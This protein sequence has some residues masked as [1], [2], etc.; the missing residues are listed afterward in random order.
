MKPLFAE[1][2]DDH[3]KRLESFYKLTAAILLDIS[4]TQPERQ[5]DKKKMLEY[6]ETLEEEKEFMAKIAGALLRPAYI[7]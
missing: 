4:R 2:K 3:Y 6:Y 7:I 1:I 5:N